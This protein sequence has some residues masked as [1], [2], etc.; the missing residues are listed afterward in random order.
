MPSDIWRRNGHGNGNQGGQ[1]LLPISRQESLSASP[2][3]LLFETDGR[4]PH[5]GSCLVCQTSAVEHRAR[6]HRAHVSDSN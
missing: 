4:L 6:V 3:T 2:R 5:G 1:L